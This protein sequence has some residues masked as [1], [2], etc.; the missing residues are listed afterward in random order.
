[1]CAMRGKRLKIAALSCLWLYY[2]ATVK[3]VKK[4][5]EFLKQN[6]NR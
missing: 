4:M 6:V 5:N 1:M 2:M 3:R